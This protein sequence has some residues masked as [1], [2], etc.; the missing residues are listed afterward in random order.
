MTHQEIL[1]KAIQKAIEG[2]WNPLNFRSSID[3]RY[4]GLKVLE[5]SY[6]DSGIL[7]FW[8][9]GQGSSVIRGDVLLGYS[10][11]DIVFD[12]EFAKALWGEDNQNWH[13]FSIG[14]N[15]SEATSKPLPSWQ[16]HLQ[17]M[18]ISLDPIAYLGDNI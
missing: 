10:N 3:K 17:H 13:T 2:G 15:E 8:E 12:H 4:K 14:P 6:Y 9:A 18:V 7:L 5:V 11:F 16:R 1:E